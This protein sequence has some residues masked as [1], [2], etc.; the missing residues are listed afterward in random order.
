[1]RTN[2]MR[3]TGFHEMYMSGTA[4]LHPALPQSCWAHPVTSDLTGEELWAMTSLGY[5]PIKLLMST[6]V[7]SL[8]FAGGVKALFK[9]LV[10]GEISDLTTMVYD[11]R[12]QVFDRVKSDAAAIGAE[13]V[14]GLKSYIVELG[15][16]LIEFVAIGTAIRKLPNFKVDTPTLPVQAIIRDK[17][18]WVSGEGAFDLQS[19]RAGG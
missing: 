19:T 3:F 16:G 13:E 9:A 12:E 10:K 6:S 4:A 7:Y 15:S 11:A 5:A 8:G 14:V 18:T 17:D 2:V 1:V